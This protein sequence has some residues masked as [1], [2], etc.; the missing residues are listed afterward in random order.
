MF[1]EILLKSCIQ[2]E[3]ENIT[4]I[5]YILY[6][7]MYNIAVMFNSYIYIYVNSYWFMP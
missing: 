5:L 3:C 4:A 7:C 6:T 1:I 2:C